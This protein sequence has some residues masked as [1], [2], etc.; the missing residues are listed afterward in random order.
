MAGSYECR[1]VIAI[2]KIVLNILVGI[3]L[4]IAM[5]VIGA[6]HL[7]DCPRQRFIP[8]YLI[9]F[10]CTLIV[11]SIFCILYLCFVSKR[12]LVIIS[13]TVGIILAL[14]NVAWL[15]AG[16]VWVFGS[17]NYDPHTTIC[18]YNVTTE[19]ANM[20]SATTAAITT[21][22]TT[23]AG[24]MSTTDCTIIMNP[25]YCHAAMFKF[26]FAVTIIYYVFLLLTFLYEVYNMI[27]TAVKTCCGRS[28][29]KDN[30]V[31]RSEVKFTPAR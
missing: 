24:Y 30:V 15:I 5:I 31:A 21:V 13:I 12:W 4:P 27:L 16:S 1:K 29:G 3:A 11:M 19:S 23:T 18:A 28:R 25:N 10:G 26:A 9:V 17:Q 22:V 2:I 14:F 20:T 8:I 7:N 6:I